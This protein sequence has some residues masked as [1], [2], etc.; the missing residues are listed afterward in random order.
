VAG[1]AL[2][3]TFLGDTTNLERA[4][5]KVNSK[6]GAVAKKAAVVG[7][8]V[9]AAALAAGKGLFEVGKTFDQVNDTIRVGTGATGKALKGLQ[10]D[11]KAVGRNVPAEFADIGT[12]VADLNTRLGLTGKP[13]QD[14]SARF[15][16]LSRI[17]GTDLATNIADITRVFGDWGIKTQDQT[18]AM[19]KLFRASQATGAGID[20]LAQQVV[21]FGAPLRQMGFNFEQSLAMFGKFE[22]EGVN[23]ET[24]MSGMRQ[25]LGR[26]AKA[27]EAPAETFR[28]VSEQI[29]NAGSVGEANAISLE[30]FGQRAGP[31]MA[32]AIREGKFELDDLV[33]TIS[34]GTDTINA[35]AKD[36]ESF[37][38]QWQMFKNRV[39]AGL[40][41]IA[42]RVFETIGAGVTWLNDNGVP[43][44]LIAGLETAIGKLRDF[45]SWVQR[46]QGWLKA[47]GGAVAGA[48]VAFGTMKIITSVIA[49][50]KNMRL[51]VLA[52]NAA[53]RAN[54]IGIIVTVL[55]ALV[56]A[57]VYAY[58][59]SETF[60]N[61]VDAAFRVVGKAAGWM[62]DKTKV[63]F[64][65][66]VTAA[67]AVW[68]WLKRNWPL[69]LGIITGPFGLAIVLVIRY[70]DQIKAAFGAAWDWITRKTGEAWN[71]I[72]TKF[73]QA[74][75]F[76]KGVW[77][78]FWNGIIGFFRQIADLIMAG[79]RAWWSN[80]QRNFQTAID[81]IRG[82]WE[83]FWNGLRDVAVRIFETVKGAIG[84]SLQ[85]VR[86]RF[87]D[88]VDWIGSKWDQLRGFLA[89]PI[90]AIIRTV[91]NKG[92]IR[93]WNFA[94][95]LL[96]GIGPAEPLKEFAW[97]RGGIHENHQAQVTRVGGPVR[98]W[99]EPETEGEAYI[100]LAQAKRARSMG[101]LSEV[102]KRFGQ[103]LVPRVDTHPYS[104]EIGAT[105]DD[106]PRDYIIF[107]DGSSR[108]GLTRTGIWPQM[109]DIVKSAFPRA[110]L[111]SAYRQGP[112]S[113]SYHST[114]R[115]IDVAGPRSMDTA[116]MGR[117]NQWL[118]GRFPNSA[119]LI[120][121]PG[122]NLLNGRRHT[123]SARTRSG[124]YDHVHWAMANAAALRGAKGSGGGGGGFM[125]WIRDR[126]RGFFERITN[127]LINML[128]KAPPRWANIGR[129]LA[130]KSRD[131]LLDF[132]LGEADKVDAAGDPGGAGVAR[133]RPL[134][135]QMLRLVGQ[136]LIHTN[137]T[138]RRMDQESGGNPRAINLWDVNAR[139]G[140]PSKGLMQ[141]IDPTFRRYRHPNLP[142]DIWHPAA[143]IASSMRYGLAR[144]GSLPRA[145]DRPGGYANGGVFTAR[146]LGVFGEDGP[147]AL[148]PLTK[149]KR[150]QQVMDQAGIGGDKHYHLTVYNAANN[151]I[152]LRAQFR[153]MEL[154]ESV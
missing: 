38:E 63:V 79:I 22:K 32:A 83:R 120:Y 89:R 138:L 17:T 106:I 71:W 141:V 8:A 144:Y 91:F 102:A 46:N 112:L 78:R 119:E 100:P 149:P 139:R 30:L 97:A 40:E 25:G 136:P 125:G 53:M 143:N 148:V 135:E 145:Y 116:F 34:N 77:D 26:M 54:P 153:R 101:I 137:R 147:E 50:M 118:A 2:T 48:V 80:L 5:D 33:N 129:G 130:T 45:G 66:L 62:W 94:A 93:A 35:A 72:T 86:D 39:L 96:P 134:V 10:D 108:K 88:A 31:D 43:E 3:V 154:L 105:R 123:Y 122:V 12:A 152:D 59:N 18:G 19:D 24:V 87:R 9:G 16:N 36:T 107:E 44:K 11:A 98:I 76:V 52:L 57:L 56:G 82:L 103:Q 142:N 13:L 128:P 4:T 65:A 37:A 14:M 68:N 6:F 51:A 131:S 140:T 114:G 121:T 126:I 15:L 95:R 47:L 28:R 7:A 21:Q 84:N 70:W 1:K 64:G 41:P 151:E 60:R 75:A 61:V 127:P 73:Q 109:W 92:I 69:L 49:W 110:R 132:L 42:S 113:G 146:T 27:G 74:T 67:K 90:N 20:S 85:W 58:Q 124:H 99:S 23:I 150:A 133:W 104:S 115:A 81:F 117:L 29:K 111:T 55:G